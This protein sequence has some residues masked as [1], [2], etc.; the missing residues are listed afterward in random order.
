MWTLHV[1]TITYQ[2]NQGIYDSG[3]ILFN[4][5]YTC[6]CPGYCNVKLNVINYIIKY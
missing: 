2:G 5:Y 4:N 3:I 1:I 6:T